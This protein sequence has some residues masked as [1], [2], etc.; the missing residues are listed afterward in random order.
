MDEFS[1]TKQRELLENQ[2]KKQQKG[3]RKEHL[4]GGE[5]WGKKETTMSC[6]VD[7]I[8]RASSQAIV[9]IGSAAKEV[10]DWLNRLLQRRKK[11]MDD[12]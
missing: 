12:P 9:R 8:P 2:T 3:F 7:D 4:F 6:D 1:A 10:I 11:G 5:K